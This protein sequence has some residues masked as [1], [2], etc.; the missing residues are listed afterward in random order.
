MKD[1]FEKNQPIYQQ[2]VDRFIS[3][4]AVGALAPGSKIR[5]VRE[6]AADFKVNPNTMQ[7]SLSKLEELGYLYTERTS[8]KYVTEN[9]TLIQT[10]K[11]RIP[12][13]ITGAFVTAMMDFGITPQDIPKYVTGYI[14]RMEHNGNSN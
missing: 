1:D 6:L 14:E 11:A 8:G 2:I 5:S 3:A 7:R 9:L 4:I 13:E 10:A 12:E